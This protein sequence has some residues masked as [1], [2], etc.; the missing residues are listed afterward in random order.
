[1][2]DEE[3][4]NFQGIQLGGPFSNKSRF[5]SET[6]HYL[7]HMI[8]VNIRSNTSKDQGQCGFVGHLVLLK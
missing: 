7:N 2:S 5:T 1:M 3:F 4:S 8:G 6:F